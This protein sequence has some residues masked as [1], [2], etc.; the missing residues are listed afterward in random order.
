MTEE[1]NPINDEESPGRNQQQANNRGNIPTQ[2]PTHDGS[3][4]NGEHNPDHHEKRPIFIRFWRALFR[5]LWNRPKANTAEI[6]AI[7]G[8]FLVG[9]IQA[10][11]Y[12]RQA[13]LTQ[14]ALEQNERGAILNRGQ[15]AVAN[16]N[17]KT[18]EESLQEIRNE[19]RP[20]IVVKEAKITT[21]EPNKVADVD[22]VV[23]NFGHSPA[24]DAR[25]IG[26]LF[27]TS[28][29]GANVPPFDVK[30][31]VNT[32]IAPPTLDMHFSLHSLEVLTTTQVERA[33]LPDVRYYL[34]GRGTY[35]DTSARRGLHHTEFCVFLTY[36]TVGVNPCPDNMRYKNTAD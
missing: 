8:I 2:P 30:V 17:V 25:F 7:V 12:Q 23:S 32:I 6:L 14:A 3:A 5:R 28:V 29:P 18:A 10:R 34:Y 11:I 26:S 16:R 35:K 31:E 24:L 22:L 36:G 33:K 21:L 9:L 20:W 19:Q 1:H 15:L 13:N 4:D 27:I